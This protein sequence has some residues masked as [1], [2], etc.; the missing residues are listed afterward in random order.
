MLFFAF[1]IGRYREWTEGSSSG[2]S[3]NNRNTGWQRQDHKTKR[4]RI[5]KTQ[6]GTLVDSP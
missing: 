4:W 2:S 3:T 5:I 6:N 1:F